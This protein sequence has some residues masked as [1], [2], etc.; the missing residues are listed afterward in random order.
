MKRYTFLLLAFFLTSTVYGT[1]FIDV[2][3]KKSANA[4]S[5]DIRRISPRNTIEVGSV[6]EPVISG[7]RTPDDQ[8]INDGNGTR[9]AVTTKVVETSSNSLSCKTYEG[10]IYDQGEAGY[11]DCI[12]SIRTDRQGTRSVP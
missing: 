10:Q 2:K 6:L 5:T 9:A 8:L 1:R 11:S 4:I 7:S 3:N 12:R